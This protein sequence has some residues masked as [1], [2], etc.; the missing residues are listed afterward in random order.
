MACTCN[1]H[2]KRGACVEC[3]IQ[4]RARNHY[5]TG[6][7]LVERDFNDEQRYFMGKERRHNQQLHGWGA[8]CG[9]K[10]TQ[11]PNPACRD[12]YVV[13]EPGLAIDCCGREILVTSEEYFD[14]Y[15]R[16]V[17]NWQKA[18]GPTSK[19][20]TN[21]HVLQICALYKECPIEEVPALF[22]ECGCDDTACRPNRI[23]ESYDVDVLIDPPA[24]PTEM[25]SV[26]VTWFTTV[27]LSG[28]RRAAVDDA[29]GRLYVLQGDPA[30]LFVYRTDTFMPIAAQSFGPAKGSDVAL[31]PDGKTVY[32]A[33]D[34]PDRVLVLD[35]NAMGTT[36]Q[37]IASAQPVTRLAVSS[38]DGSLYVL[39]AADKTVTVWNGAGT[40]Q[41]GT[42]AVDTNPAAMAPS[43][44]GTL[45]FVANS[46]AA[47]VSVIDTTN[48]AAVPT[49]IPMAGASPSALAVAATT[50][51]G[52]L[53]VADETN[54]TVAIFGVQPGAPNPY[55]AQ[56]NP[57][58]LA[59]NSPVDIAASPAGRWI[60]ALV[61]DAGGKGYVQT[62]DANLA[63]TNSPN[64][65]GP[66]VPMG[67]APEEQILLAGNGSE[68]F[69]TYSGPAADPLGGGVAVA[70][71]QEQACGDIFKKAL[72]GCPDCSQG[73]CVVLA[74]IKG[75]V[76]QSAVTDAEIDNWTDRHLLPSTELL[77]EVVECLLNNGG[78]GQQGEQ[79]PPGPKGDKGDPGPPGPQGAPG[80]QGDPG[81]PGP[82]GDKGDPG[83]GLDPDLTHICATN[84][85]PPNWR[86]GASLTPVQVRE[87]GLLVAFDKPVRNADI[88]ENSF[89][90]LFRRD[91]Q[92]LNCWC[93]VPGKPLGGVDLPLD[94]D[95]QTGLCK[96][97]GAA[98][99]SNAQFVR[100]ARFM[101]T[102]FQTG[103]YR[104]LVKGNFIRDQK[105]RGV[106]ADHL[107]GWLPERRTGD[108]VEGGTF[109]SWFTIAQQ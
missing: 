33:V 9:L 2:G 44:D 104:V 63:A 82:K 50:G 40:T 20:D 73:N 90:V 78:T 25:G 96:I 34:G 92:G 102:E 99:P 59:P 16:F 56:G 94:L 106:D 80:P 42:V 7:L 19:P 17:A 41:L 37:T 85:T 87:Q 65:V 64:A 39:T 71:V 98:K 60:Y 68:L 109:E 76:D 101:L 89:I 61:Q 14:F 53:F 70:H 58:S 86:Q 72:D 62:I 18:H 51:G 5:F 55:P 95:P 24:A 13:I 30:T 22:D 81:P 107:P 35:A 4:Q 12:R 36:V 31:S 88:D 93:E 103:K 69:V 54:S 1:E 27:G 26:G 8:V 21:P 3:D 43:P 105:G 11:H 91:E 57:V 77:T 67:E 97:T 84:F 83:T 100:G 108:M 29:N 46:G 10:V 47:S 28:A 6:K 74:T 38:R 66:A 15:D 75:Y 45:M 32:L 23:L 49:A 52:R 48:L 79:G